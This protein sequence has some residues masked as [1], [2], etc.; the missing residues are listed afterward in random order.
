M[1]RTPV[2]VVPSS[3]DKIL[4]V[5]EALFARSGYSGI[6]M[7]EVATEVGLGKSSLFHHFES[8]RS[9]YF[10][11]LER[12]LGRVAEHLAPAFAAPH[13]PTERLDA[14]SDAL[15][16]ALAEHPTSAR[17]LLRSL[18]EVDPFPLGDGAAPEAEA[19]DAILLA[20]IDSFQELISEGINCGEFREV[21]VGH[22][23]Q[24]IIGVA[25]FHFASGEFGNSVLGEPLFSADAIARRRSEQKAF[26]HNALIRD[27]G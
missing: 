15:I 19:G 1:A 7:R 13:S 16:D 6:G 9:L 17:L 8:K 3:R 24:T 23:T 5:A 25:V 14:L 12:V 10:L 21:S 18:F 2:P 11:V 22:T 4:D 26:F 20:L 27:A